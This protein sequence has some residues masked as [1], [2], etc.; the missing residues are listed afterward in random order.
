MSRPICVRALAIASAILFGLHVV[1]NFFELTTLPVIHTVI[2]SAAVDDSVPNCR[3][4]REP[5]F[6][7]EPLDQQAGLPVLVQPLAPPVRL[8]VDAVLDEH[9]PPRGVLLLS[10]GA[11]GKAGQSAG[12][13]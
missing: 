11:L 9:A 13:R 2:T 4:R 6:A 5:D 7:P 3:D 10:A 8:G 12:R 1:M